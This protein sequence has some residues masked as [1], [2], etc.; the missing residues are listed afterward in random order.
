MELT[1][2]CIRGCIVAPKGKKLCVSDL[3][4]IEG[5]AAA[6]L[7]G[8]DWK[9]DAF[10]NYD[11]GTGADLYKIAYAAAFDITPEEVDGGAKSGLQRQIGKVM[12]LMLQYEGGVGAFLT[13]A[14]SYGIDLDA[15]ADVA[16]PNIPPDILA[17]ARKAWEWAV[18]KRSTFGLSQRT[19][20]ACDALKRLWRYAHPE[21]V[22]YWAELGATVKSAINNPGKTFG[23]RKLKIRRNGAW[24]RIVLPSRRALCY[25]SPRITEGGKISY[26]G[27]NQYSKKYGVIHTY[28]GKLFENIC[29]AFARDIMAYNMPRI[30][31]AGYEIVLSVHDELITEAP[32][33]D[34]YTGD[35]LSELLAANPPW[36]PDMPL[37]A[38]GFH[39]PRY[40][41]D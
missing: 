35:G 1:S 23:C 3:S 33:N 12:E 41:K 6:Y 15:M 38:G 30:E 28:G 24:L 25:P 32:D 18:K 4:N 5:R 13:G 17:E 16:L 31:V 26:K 9:L 34:N 29:Q 37:A 11:A 22:S 10:R 27:M 14:A 19:Y 39:S 20:M 40:K 2:S 36:A 7:A 21:I 8:E